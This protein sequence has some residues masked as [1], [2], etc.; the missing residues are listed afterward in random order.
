MRETNLQFETPMK[1][2]D[3]YG[4]FYVNNSENFKFLSGEK[5][6]IKQLVA[7]VKSVVDR[8]GVNT[9][10]SH[11]KLFKSTQEPTSQI[12]PNKNQFI[13]SH[14][15]KQLISTAERNAGRKKGGYRYESDLQ[16]FAMLLR[17][18]SGPLGY[19]TLQSNLEGVLPS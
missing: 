3:V 5:V 19:Q 9:G 11:F 8:I 17:M 10:L 7:H 2:E 1:A 15:L 4:K 13:H 12:S 16:H 14:F 6:L 18:L